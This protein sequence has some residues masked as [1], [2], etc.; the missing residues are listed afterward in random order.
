MS[1]YYHEIYIIFYYHAITWPRENYSLLSCQ[2]L[3]TTCKQE[4]RLLARPPNTQMLDCFRRG[5]GGGA[6]GLWLA[7]HMSPRLCEHKEVR[8][9][10]EWCANVQAY[11][12]LWRQLSSKY[13]RDGKNKCCWWQQ[14]ICRNSIIFSLHLR[15]FLRPLEIKQLLIRLLQVLQQSSPSLLPP[16]TYDLYSDWTLPCHM[17]PAAF[18]HHLISDANIPSDS[19]AWNGYCVCSN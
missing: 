12:S 7:F 8:M 11:L 14:G 15:L 19:H 16:P 9:T 4:K 6:R 3:T 17:L 2:K 5:E 13:C 1:L 18:P 10:R